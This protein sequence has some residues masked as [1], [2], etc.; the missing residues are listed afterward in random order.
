VAGH[1]LNSRNSKRGLGKKSSTNGLIF[2]VAAAALIAS[3]WIKDYR[4]LS[5]TKT[6]R[7]TLYQNGFTYES[8]GQ[9]DSCRWEEIRDITHRSVQIHS[10]HAP[11]RRVRLIWSVLKKDGELISFAETLDLTKI[12]RLIETARNE[13]IR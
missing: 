7:L 3:F 4:K 6:L 2:F 1:T 9:K 10:K 13:A 12:T 11:P 5:K 8:D